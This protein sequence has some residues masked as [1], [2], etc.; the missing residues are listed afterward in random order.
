MKNT[1]DMTEEQANK[2][3]DT[4]TFFGSYGFNKSHATA[5]GMIAYFSMYR[6]EE[7]R[8]GK[9]CRSRWSQYH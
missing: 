7:R 8:V 4:I 5:Y 2:I 9:E 3:M 1:P 6:S